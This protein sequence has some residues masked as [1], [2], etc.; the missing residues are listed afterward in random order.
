MVYG[1]Y[2]AGQGNLD[3]D[4]H[5]PQVVSALDNHFLLQKLKYACAGVLEGEAN[6]DPQK[7][8]LLAEVLEY[9]ERNKRQLSKVTLVYL[10]AF[11]MLQAELVG[12][13]GDPHFLSF[14]DLYER[15]ADFADDEA[16]DLF[17]HGQN[18]CVLQ[19]RRGHLEYVDRIQDLYNRMLGSG[20]GLRDGLLPIWVYKNAVALMCKLGKLEWVESFVE[21]Y[22]D[23]IAHDPERITYVYNLAV[24]RFY[25]SNFTVTV[26]LLYNHVA[27]LDNFQIGEDARL[28]L[29]RGLWEIGEFEWLLSVLSAFE[30][31]LRRTNDIGSD[32]RNRY[33]GFIGYL[34][35]ACKAVTGRPNQIQKQLAMIRTDIIANEPQNL[36]NWLLAKLDEKTATNS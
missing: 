22:R 30:Q 23:N 15:P 28:Y 31:H 12:E 13:D 26:E 7:S 35:R 14:N 20:T 19:Y 3:Q 5:L 24:L 1:H 17:I 4:K 11:R 16:M 6:S 32:V 10:H 21:T 8:P 34:R 27:G 18:F 36:H 29:C 2:L 33:K 9:V 25:Q